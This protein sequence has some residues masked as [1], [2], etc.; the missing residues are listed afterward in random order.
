MHPLRADEF[1]PAEA[2]SSRTPA[3]PVERTRGPLRA[4]RRV[5]PSDAA[6]LAFPD[7]RE[8]RSSPV[9]ADGGA[10]QLLAGPRVARDAELTGTGPR[11]AAT[12][13]RLGRLAPLLARGLDPLTPLFAVARLVQGVTAGAVLRADGGCQVVPGLATTPLLLPGSPVLVLARRRVGDGRVS[14]SFLWPLGGAHAP[15]GHARVTTVSASDDT[16]PGLVGLAL[17]SPAP[18]LHGLTPR[19]LEV[20]GLLVEGCTNPDIA[21]RLV[22]TPRTVATHLE[23]IL[24]KLGTPTRTHAAVRAERDGLYVP[25]LPG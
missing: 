16:C 5:V 10:V 19:E 2:T 22:V 20:L 7:T 6:F 11:A 24:A 8:R 12:R 23:H 14:S 25:A 18:P 9:D 21:C 1:L 3:T 15:G 17:L 4:L 13:R